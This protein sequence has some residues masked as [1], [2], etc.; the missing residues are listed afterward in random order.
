MAWE[1][2]Y[3]DTAKRSLKRLGRD[4]AKRIVD[5]MDFRVGAAADP[6]Q[7]GKALSGPLNKLWRY[8]VGDC[9][10]LCDIQ[11]EKIRIMV[12]DVGNR[13]DVYRRK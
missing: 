1:I 11:D 6:R 12:V 13:G 5:Y 9:R 7:Y 10:I 8:R 4:T 3:A 2:E